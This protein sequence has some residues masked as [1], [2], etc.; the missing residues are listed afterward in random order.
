MQKLSILLT[1]FLFG[2]QTPT[3]RTIPNP[4]P[5]SVSQSLKKI[6]NPLSLPKFSKNNVK[7]EYFTGGKV[8]SK[9]IMSDK[10]G[11]NGVLKKYGYSGKLT[12]T[13]PIAGGVMH[14]IETLFDEKGRIIKKTPYTNGKKHG[15]LEVYYPNGDLM[16]Q[17]TYVNNIREGK[18][19]KY[20]K[21][22]SINQE[23]I[24][25]NGQLVN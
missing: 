1:F 15:I 10:T 4:L 3:P 17:I 19:I 16:A 6:P 24:F 14:G 11:L 9:F 5:K 12:S 23:V 21:D 20:N 25:N 7:T 2:C 18:A 13:V 8:R 22:G